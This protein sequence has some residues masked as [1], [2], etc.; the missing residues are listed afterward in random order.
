LTGDRPLPQHSGMDRRRFLL[1]SLAV[2]LATPLAAHAGARSLWTLRQINFDDGTVNETKGLERRACEER[3][4]D[5]E[6]AAEDKMWRIEIKWDI[7]RRVRTATTRPFLFCIP[8]HV[9][10]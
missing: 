3:R 7:A 1:I 8:D 5:A 4:R 9:V 2:A 6:R 10:P